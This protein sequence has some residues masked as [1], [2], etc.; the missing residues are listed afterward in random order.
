MSTLKN[1]PIRFKLI[2]GFV[3]IITINSVSGFMS[4]N[5]MKHLGELVNLTYDKALMSGTFA[6]ASKFDFSQYDSEIKSALLSKS[7]EDFKKHTFK[8]TRIYNT[9]IDDLT[10]VEERAL[11]SKSS[12]IVKEIIHN[13]NLIEI[14]KNSIIKNKQEQLSKNL[15]SSSMAM[16]QTWDDN[17]K[18]IL[19]YKKLTA[20]Y[21]DAAEVGYN[22]RLS[23]E[24]NNKKNLKRTVW[25]LI[26]CLIVGLILSVLISFLVIGPLFKLKNICLKVGEGDYSIRSDIKS[27]DE[28]GTLAASFNFMLNT[29]EEKNEN[30]TSLLSSLP[31]GLFYFDENGIISKER[32]LSTDMIFKKFSSYKTLTDF[33]NAHNCENRKIKKIIDATFKGLIPFD[34]AVFLFPDIIDNYDEEE[35]KKIQLS[36]KP[37]YELGGKLEKVILIA[38]DITEKNKA[39][40]ESSALSERVDRV[41]KVSYDIPGFKEFLPAARDVFNTTIKIFSNF[42]T[43]KEAEL[44][45]NLHSLKGMLGVYSFKSCATLIHE[46][47]DFLESEL[48]EKMNESLIK[49][50][51][52]YESFEDQ[53]ADVMKLLALNNDNG[54]KYYDTR[55]INLVKDLAIKQ[56]N[57]EIIAAL[58]NLDRFPI[59]KVLA[60]YSSHAQ[61]I[62]EK[63]EDKKVRLVFENSDEISFEEVQ[64]ID[65][66]LVHIL[67]N[68]IDHGIENQ[69]ARIESN[70]NE[71]GEIRISCKRYEDHSLEFKISDDGQG[72]NTEYL[73]EKALKLGLVNNTLAGHIN[74][75]EKLNLIFISGLSSKDE[76][77]ETSGRGVGMD[78]VKN[79]IESIGGTIQL[80]TKLG[81]GTTFSLKIPAMTTA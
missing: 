57:T 32:S 52:I 34:S 35:P 15:T 49:F 64:R 4:V 9:L 16:A 54:I 72:I 76:K 26:F 24:E 38:E 77:T 74:E 6:Q 79:Y 47:E 17:K 28:F 70:K 66:V 62:A 23:S 25:I 67:N 68:S 71:V 22:L 33:Y 8:S 43:S 10:V 48:K 31:F 78:A 13:L 59:E 3:I 7:E 45:R 2:I 75:E 58:A 50:K 39:L 30:I 65:A 14:E 37:K 41:S 46:L 81:I 21:D 20:L 53:S 12:G 11:S 69:S 19:V 63:L 27:R 5:I 60:K 42:D 61:S 40:T 56:N 51:S 80:F 18:K 1:I 29:I 55:K 44:K 73:F 36:F